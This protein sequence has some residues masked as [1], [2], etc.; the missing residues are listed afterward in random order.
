MRY[1]LPISSSRCDMGGVCVAVTSSTRKS[2][3]SLVQA[4]RCGVLC[5]RQRSPAHFTRADPARLSRSH[6]VAIAVGATDGRVATRKARTPAQRAYGATVRHAAILRQERRCIEQ[7]RPAMTHGDTNSPRPGP[8]KACLPAHAEALACPW[9]VTGGCRAHEGPRTTATCV[10]K[11][12]APSGAPSPPAPAG[13]HGCSV[14]QQTVV[15]AR[16]TWHTVE[17]HCGA[18]GPQRRW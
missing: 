14:S 13:Q 16:H 1:R 15:G 7:R 11:H 3:R 18:G 17:R 5:P 10:Q 12:K 6:P 8:E 9:R 2:A 4:L